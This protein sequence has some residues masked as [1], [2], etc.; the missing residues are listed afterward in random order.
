MSDETTDPTPEEKY[1]S[2]T[3]Y[4]DERDDAIERQDKHG[5]SDET[6]LPRL[7]DAGEE[8]GPAPASED[9]PDYLPREN[10]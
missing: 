4:K 2:K 3:P 5:T 8:Q 7:D 6:K 1:V 10:T 9:S